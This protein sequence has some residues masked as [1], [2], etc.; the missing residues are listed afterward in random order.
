MGAGALESE[1]G[2]T[3]ERSLLEQLVDAYVEAH[4]TFHPH[5]AT[6]NGDHRFDHDLGD[7]TADAVVDLL[8][9]VR[10]LL[11]ATDAF[12]PAQL[13]RDERIEFLLLVSELETTELDLEHIRLWAHDPS[14]LLDVPLTACFGLLIADEVPVEDRAAALEARLEQIPGWLAAGRATIR[15]AADPLVETTSATAGAARAFI[16]RTVPAWMEA[17]APQ[18]LDHLRDLIERA[19][20]ALERTVA[21]AQ[22]L[23]RTE[24][25]GVG[26]AGFAE[27]LRVAHLLNESPS[28]LVERG[29]GIIEQTQELLEEVAARRD[30]QHSWREQVEELR[31]DHPARDALV[32]EYEQAMRWSRQLVREHELAPPAPGDPEL[33][34]EPT[35]GPWRST[36]P[37]AAYLRPAPFGAPS[38]G[39]FWVTPPDDDAEQQDVTALLRDHP[40]ASL[41]VVAVH[42]GYPGHHQQLAWA[43]AHPSPL[44]RIVD[45]SAFVEGWGLY[46]EELFH[47]HG[48][49]DDATRL[50]QL[51]DRLWRG[52]RVIVDV[53]LHTG[54]LDVDGCVRQLVEVAGLDPRN[55][56][57]EVRRYAGSPTQ[58][59]SYA[60][61]MDALVGVRERVQRAEGADFDERDFHARLLRNGTLPP[62]L[63]EEALLG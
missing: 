55:A 58:P 51:K 37:Y 30:P 43:N 1:P 42:E 34:V 57:A 62:A 29:E 28:E 5:L 33:L 4:H 15:R 44:R 7:P 39:R 47:E 16:G 38:V 45:A 31:D 10:T 17:N 18:R 2:R 6:L 61:G 24:E 25:A 54:E 13:D 63:A 26:E 56:R 14:R 53:G 48:L 59:M 41:K 9:L 8:T 21:W 20:A 49:Y 23:P 36:V 27:R 60:I 52:V 3:G 11:R 40:R 22:Q 32:S 46:C 12:D 50:W 19:D 35:P